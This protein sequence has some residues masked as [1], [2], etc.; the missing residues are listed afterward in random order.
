MLWTFWPWCFRKGRLG[1]FSSSASPDKFW[2]ASPGFQVSQLLGDDPT[3]YLAGYEQLKDTGGPWLR[4]TG[5]CS[6]E[7]H[8]LTLPWWSSDTESTC[9]CMGHRF[10]PWSGR[11][12]RALEQLSPCNVMPKSRNLP[13]TTRES[14]CDA[15]AREFF[16]YQARAGAPT[17]TITDSV[18]IGRS[19]G[20]WITLLV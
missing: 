3:F 4:V 20:F 1:P 18:A 5:I 19:P 2:G 9:Q 11:I 13:M 6:V 12:P 17:V 8:S 14:M 7:S 10:D 16:Y 15:K